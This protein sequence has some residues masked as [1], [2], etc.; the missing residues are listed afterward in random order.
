MV[1]GDSPLAH[2]LI[3]ELSSKYGEHVTA[4][5][6]S[7][8]RHHGPQIGNLP[9]VRVIESAELTDEAFKDA[10]VAEA[11]ALA[12]VDEG[13][14]A[15]IHA[16]LRAQEINPDLRLVIRIGNASLGRRLRDLFADCA[17]LSDAA[18]AAPAFVAAALGELTPTHVR[19]PGRTL[20]V[21]R[22]GTAPA[23][24]I[25]CG[26]ADTTGPGGPRLLPIDQDHADLVLAVADGTPSEPSARRGERGEWTLLWPWLAALINRKLRIT[27]FALLGLLVLATVLFATV[28]HNSLSDSIYLTLLDAAGA[29]Q[30]DTDHLSPVNK[31]VQV[32]VTLIGIALIP[33]FTAAVV[34]AV[35][36]ARLAGA[37]GRRHAPT[38]DHV[39]VVGL[40]HVGGRVV[41]QLHDLGVPVV[42]VE[43]DENAAGVATARRH[44]LPIVFANANRSETLHAAHV[45]ASRALVVLTSDDVTN[46]EVALHARA[47]APNLRVA[48]RVFDNDFAERIQR[49][50]GI[51]SSRS[52]SFLAAPAFAAAMVERQVIDTIP[53]ERHVLLIADVRVAHGSAL[54]GTRIE[55]VHQPGEARVIALRRRDSD[56]L[57][58][59]LPRGYEVRAEDRLVVLATRTGLSR[60]FARGSSAGNGFPA[61]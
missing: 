17:L 8:R 47:L 42:C 31:I 44:G 4:I 46:L 3:D 33:V 24:H 50:F 9:G 26:L 60:I 39:I 51:N 23:S 18:M 6:S 10:G 45:G 57:E 13:D 11:R 56:H 37:D 55:D 58:W 53:V 59:A 52:V 34:D 61:Y 49:N 35:V 41:A 21:A 22:R 32:A 1:C 54:P 25:V 38:R 14:V 48:M 30:P 7:K 43:R 36:G 2:R 19:L 28:G 27:L 40:G 12:L 5:V 16:A 29:A 20:K 15:N